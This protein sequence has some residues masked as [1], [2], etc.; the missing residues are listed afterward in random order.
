MDLAERVPGSFSTASLTTVVSGNRRLNIFA[1]NGVSATVHNLVREA[2]PYY[3]DYYLIIG[4]E[5][6]KTARLFLDFMYSLEA[7]VILRSL[8]N[9]PLLK[10]EE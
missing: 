8:G 4:P 6:S 7:T 10:G 2:Y 9:I 3:I 1:I 5:A